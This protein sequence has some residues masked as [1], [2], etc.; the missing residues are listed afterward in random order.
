MPHT[1]A[2]AALI[3][4]LVSMTFLLVTR[5]ADEL[6]SLL[7]LGGFLIGIFLFFGFLYGGF[8]LVVMAAIVVLGGVH[9]I[10][11]YVPEIVLFSGNYWILLLS[12]ALE[13]GMAVW[14]LDL[15]TRVAHIIQPTRAHIS[16][17]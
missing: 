3:A 10:G 1:A 11:V 12:F 5:F 15:I 2:I 13:V 14:N 4:T 6:L 8:I 16:T 9:W 7:S 17:A